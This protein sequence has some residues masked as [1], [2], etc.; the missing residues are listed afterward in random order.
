MIDP[1]AIGEGTPIFNK[2]KH[3][4]N[5]KLIGTK[6]FKSGVVLLSYMPA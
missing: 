5:L 2:I 6:T 4:L 3:Q 1:V